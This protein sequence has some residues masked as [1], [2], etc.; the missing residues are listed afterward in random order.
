M[1]NKMKPYSKQI[2]GLKLLTC[3][4]W[5]FRK[6]SPHW[7]KTLVLLL[8]NNTRKDFTKEYQLFILLYI[9]YIYVCIAN[10]IGQFNIDEDVFSLVL[11]LWILNFKQTAV[12]V[13]TAGYR[14]KVHHFQMWCRW[15][16]LSSK[17]GNTTI[18][19]KLHQVKRALVFQTFTT[20]ALLLTLNGTCHYLHSHRK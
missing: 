7:F 20:G 3:N 2:N 9:L 6:L 11:H 5:P 19:F 8:T 18:E 15:H 13:M 1:N 16:Q 10:V 12:M 4:I 14:G 17:E